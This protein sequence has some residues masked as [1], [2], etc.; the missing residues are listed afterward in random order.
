M[1][2]RHTGEG[3]FFT[4]KAVDRFE[5]ES[6]TLHWI[7]DNRFGDMTVRTLDSPV[8]GTK[9]RVEIEQ[10]TARELTDVFDEYTEDFEFSRTRTIVKL[11]AIGT[12][13][14]SRS[15]AKRLLHGI[16]KF[17][18]VVLDFKDVD[19][20]GQGFADEVFRIWIRQHP[21]VNLIPTNMSEPVAFMVERA[22]RGGSALG[23]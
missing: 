21:E 18:E 11:F 5:I 17:R 14:I 1:P 13:F 6:G 20:V 23:S 2:E 19:F 10:V 16:T 15:Q 8:K 9:V 12:E 7:V 3:I 4:S 22:L